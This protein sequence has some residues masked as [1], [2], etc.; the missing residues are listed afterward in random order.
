MGGP[1][2]TAA[3]R[4]DLVGKIEGYAS[5]KDVSMGE[6]AKHFGITGAN[7]FYHKKQLKRTGGLP[8][9]TPAQSEPEL[10]A[11]REKLKSMPARAQVVEAGP[12]GAVRVFVF[13]GSPEQVMKS[14]STMFW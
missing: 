10:D 13:E 8:T 5:Q 6:A 7:Y 12:A 14:M 9:F 1:R 4:R 11:V 3:D 2:M